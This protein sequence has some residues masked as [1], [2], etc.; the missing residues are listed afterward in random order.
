MSDIPVT[1]YAIHKKIRQNTTLA[2]LLVILAA[3]Q[4]ALCIFLQIK[5]SEFEEA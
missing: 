4:F 5:G 3:L 1:Y 2:T